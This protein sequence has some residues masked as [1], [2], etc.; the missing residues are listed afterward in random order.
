MI[1]GPKLITAEKGGAAI[2]NFEW[3]VLETCEAK[4]KWGRGD[5]SS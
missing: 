3:S 1:V 4:L 2:L 5:R